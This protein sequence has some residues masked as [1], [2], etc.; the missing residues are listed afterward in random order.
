MATW[1][2]GGALVLIVGVVIRKMLLDR[3]SGKHACA[4]GGDCAHCHAACSAQP[5]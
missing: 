5:R 3:R 1:I 4:C 2:V